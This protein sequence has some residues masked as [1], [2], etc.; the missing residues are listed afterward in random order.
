MRASVAFLSTVFALFLLFAGFF[1]VYCDHGPRSVWNNQAWSPEQEQ[2]V[3]ITLDYLNNKIGEG[4]EKGPEGRLSFYTANETSHLADVR[5]LF[6]WTKSIFVF[7]GLV[8]IVSGIVSWRRREVRTKKERRVKGGE[9]GTAFRQVLLWGGVGGLGF[10]LALS[11]LSLL[12]FTW[13]WSGPFH[14][15]L[16]PQGNWMFPADSVLITLFP[17]TFFRG[18]AMQVLAATAAFST[19]ALMAAY[20]VRIRRAG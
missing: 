4:T 2:Q 1:V 20:T 16:F 18:F 13:F 14:E 8:L 10:V 9:T 5:H 15:L 17:E 11:L 6:N 3:R 12:D 19:L 7:L